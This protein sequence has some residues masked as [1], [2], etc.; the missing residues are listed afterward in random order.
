MPIRP[1]DLQTLLMQLSQVGRDQSAEKDAALRASMQTAANQVKQVEQ[2]E[3]VR[4]PENPDTGPQAI[5]DRQ[6]GASAGT[7]R[8]KEEA[9]AEKQETE[10]EVIRDP[11]LGNAVDLSG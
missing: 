2:K 1:I 6:G 7:G 9:E 3:A 8:K 10:E 11:S 4:E 5:K